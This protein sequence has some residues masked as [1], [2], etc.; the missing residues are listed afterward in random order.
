MG[1]TKCSPLV[2][3]VRTEDF[4]ETIVSYLA[5]LTTFYWASSSYIQG[6]VKEGRG[7][8]FSKVG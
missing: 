3:K 4:P 1:M 5:D 6:G 2:N 7:F 8:S